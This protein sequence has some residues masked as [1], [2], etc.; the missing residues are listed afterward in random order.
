MNT[1]MTA[2]PTYHF[3]LNNKLLLLSYGVLFFSIIFGALANIYGFEDDA[4]ITFRFSHN[5]AD[6]FWFQW[7]RDGIPIEGFSNP[8]WT[9][10]VALL[11][12]IIPTENIDSA[13]YFLSLLLLI[14]MATHIFYLSTLEFR[15]NP[16]FALLVVLLTL[17]HPII[18]RSYFNGLET[19]L[20]AFLLYFSFYILVFKRKKSILFTTLLLLLILNRFEGIA[21]AIGFAVLYMFINFFEQKKN[22]KKPEPYIP[23]ISVLLFFIA[24]EL[25]RYSIFGYF[26]PLSVAAKSS[27]HLSHSALPSIFTNVSGLNY[28]KEFLLQPTL[29][30]VYSFLMFGVFIQ[31]S[32][33]L[34]FFYISLIAMFAGASLII[35]FNQGDWMGGFRLLSPFVPTMLLLTASVLSLCRHRMNTKSTMNYLIL[36]GIALLA[37]GGE[38]FSTG[39]YADIKFNKHYFSTLQN[40]GKYWSSIL[41]KDEL[42]A[43]MMA[44]ALAY[45]GKNLNTI[46]YNGL[47]FPCIGRG[48]NPSNIYGKDWD[49][50]CIFNPQTK[51]FDTQ[52]LRHANIIYSYAINHGIELEVVVKVKSILLSDNEQIIFIR[53]DFI[54]AYKK[55]D[56]SAI[57]VPFNEYKNNFIPNHTNHKN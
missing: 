54:P 20:Q 35:L 39:S 5:I 43:T 49:L 22:I 4:Y 28:L 6:G 26:T 37:F 56:S 50:N 34:I 29:I 18:W 32:K 8:L 25:L 1:D 27:G 30:I 10:V 15:L 7:N 53:K 46:D 44:G 52:F 40:A 3:V 14:A 13:V 12:A 48:N 23:L 16:V 11:H 41:N 57:I 36:I 55:R 47:I 24:Y 31:K 9:L 33:E 45:G 38:V 42:Y 2:S 17:L 19:I 51:I 21:Y